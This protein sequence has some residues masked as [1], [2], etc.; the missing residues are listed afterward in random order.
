M[1]VEDFSIPQEMI[2]DAIMY[3][4]VIVLLCIVSA[5]LS[6][7]RENRRLEKEFAAYQQRRQDE[8]HENE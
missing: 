5:A 4:L 3:I 1:Y 6:K 7:W 8:A 2:N